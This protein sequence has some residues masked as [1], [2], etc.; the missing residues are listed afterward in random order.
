MLGNETRAAA[1]AQPLRQTTQPAFWSEATIRQP[2]GTRG[3]PAWAGCPAGHPLSTTVVPA[4]SG[5]EPGVNGSSSVQVTSNA[6]GTHRY[7]A[8]EEAMATRSPGRSW[9]AS[10]SAL[11]ACAFEL[12][13][14]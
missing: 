1:V 4:G 13:V 9:P 14:R 12:L 8:S 7:Q 6:C 11:A 3:H 2:A 5:C 10:I